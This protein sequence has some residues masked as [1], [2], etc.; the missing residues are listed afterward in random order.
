[1]TTVIIKGTT[2]LCTPNNK[3]SKVIK[4][5]TKKKK[6]KKAITI[7]KQPSSNFLSLITHL[8]LILTAAKIQKKP[9]LAIG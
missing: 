5:N 7:P 8:T 3:S 9:T 6:Q 2:I 4:K 1:M